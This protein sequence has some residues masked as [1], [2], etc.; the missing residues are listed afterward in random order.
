VSQVKLNEAGEGDGTGDKVRKRD[1]LFKYLGT[2]KSSLSQVAEQVYKNEA[3]QKTAA[4][5]SGAVAGAG[6]KVQ[7]FR[8]TISAKAG[9]AGELN[10]ERQKQYTG[11]IMDKMAT[12]AGGAAAAVGFFLA[13]H[14]EGTESPFDMARKQ[15]RVEVVDISARNSIK[16]S[17]IVQPGD[18][19]NWTF[20]V[21]PSQHA[22]TVSAV[23]LAAARHQCRSK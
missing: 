8:S 11:W 5:V 21:F 16:T 14:Q 19:L 15:E 1:V 3:L 18:T 7:E 2:A 17:L 12:P 4:R 13:R 23:R 20:G 10:A 6:T 22:P 9:E